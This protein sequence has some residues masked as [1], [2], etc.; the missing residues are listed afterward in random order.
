MNDVTSPAEPAAPF[1]F[2]IIDLLCLTFVAALAT[3][4]LRSHDLHAYLPG[5][6]SITLAALLAVIIGRLRKSIATSVF[7]AVL[8][9]AMMQVMVTEVILLHRTGVLVW[10]LATAFSAAIVAT[11]APHLYRRMLLGASCVGLPLTVYALLVARPFSLALPN[12][13]SAFIGG[14][15]LAVVISLCQWLDTAKGIRQSI[16][17]AALASGAIAIAWLEHVT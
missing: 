11:A 8:L 9:A 6:L 3:A 12:I 10:P 7:W 17:A 13:A 14:A 1:Q 16:S 15:G 4:Y 2:G 5:L